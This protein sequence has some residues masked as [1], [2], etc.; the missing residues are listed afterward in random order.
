MSVLSHDVVSGEPRYEIK[1]VFERQHLPL[2]RSWALR[3]WAA[4]R[5]AYPPRRVNN[6]YFDTFE[7]DFLLDHV[8]GV[9]DRSKVRFRWYGEGWRAPQ[10]QLEVKRKQGRLSFKTVFLVE[11]VLDLRELSWD[12]LLT[13]L[14]RQ[15]P[16]Q[17]ERLLAGL[18]PRLV[19]HYRREYYVNAEGDIRLT[20]DYDLR[21]YEQVSPFTLNLRFPQPLLDEMV[22]EFKAPLRAHRRLAD[23]LAAFPLRCVD[24]SKY[25][26][27]LETALL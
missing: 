14:R 21:A 17:G 20:L 16:P 23:V 22:V 1:M 26:R 4:F 11:Q 3:H 24:N 6:V 12:A 8:D 5:Q 2:V 10:G 13:H 15:L 7:H 9:F 19:S 18:V 27:G 25:L